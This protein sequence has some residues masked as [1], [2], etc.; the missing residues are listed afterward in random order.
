M[1]SISYWTM[2]RTTKEFVSS[3]YLAKE[4]SILKPNWISGWWSKTASLPPCDPNKT[5]IDNSR[6]RFLKLLAEGLGSSSNIDILIY[7]KKAFHQVLMDSD[8]EL[9]KSWRSRLLMESTP[10]GNIVMFYDIFKQGF[11]YY[12]DQPVVPYD[13]LN[14]VAMKYVARFSCMDF[15]MDEYVLGD[16][17][18]SPLKVVFIEDDEKKEEK[19]PGSN[20]GLDLKNA[21]FAKLKNYS[22]GS[23]KDKQSGGGGSGGS[24]RTPVYFRT[25]YPWLWKIWF[26]IQYYL[27]LP[28]YKVG[29]W[30]WRS[31]IDGI[32]GK[33]WR[34]VEV[35][36]VASIEETVV[37][38][39]KLRNKFIYLGRFRNLN[40]L[41]KPIKKGV[42]V[43]GST[44]YDSM[45]GCVGG[46]AISYKDFKT[47]GAVVS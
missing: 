28:V 47:G 14:S 15:F 10:L 12:C 16:R 26:R 11:S 32:F 21:P 42:F 3:E 19:K 34:A 9:E 5:Y 2:N 39:E 46:K 18:S 6:A 45:F 43:G 13:I 4:S 44:K 17:G 23:K 24:V 1:F 31:L 41:Q 27:V 29:L 35:A 20:L 30:T 33:T 22:V 40:V 25:N 8:N 7:N 37:E 38:K 36:E